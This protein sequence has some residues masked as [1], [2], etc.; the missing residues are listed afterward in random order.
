[1][2][3]VFNFFLLFILTMNSAKAAL[4]TGSVLLFVPSWGITVVAY[5]Y[6]GKASDA[7]IEPLEKLMNKVFFISGSIMFLDS[8]EETIQAGLEKKFPNM[9]DYVLSEVAYLATQKA[10]SIEENSL[11]F[12]EITFNRYEYDSIDLLIP[13]DI[14]TETRDN[15]KK[16]L[17]SSFKEIKKTKERE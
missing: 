9:P 12:K 15:F 14:D 11:G 4:L 5:H 16:L 13:T 6:A 1:M 7:G 3:Y 2:K 17:T 8:N 10:Q